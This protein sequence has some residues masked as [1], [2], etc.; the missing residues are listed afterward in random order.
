MYTV[1][2]HI[3]PN[4]K[5]YIGITKQEPEQRWKNG[6]GYKTNEHFYRAILKYGWENIRH[7]IV[8]NGLTK[9]QACDLEIELIAK[10][11][12]TNPKHGYNN[13]MGGETNIPSAETRKKLSE[14]NKGANNPQ[15]GKHPSAETLRK[16]SEATKGVNN[17][18]YGKHHSHEA[19]RKMSEARKGK[20][21]FWKG[22]HLSAETRKK[23]SE[24]NKGRHLSA[25]HR[26]KISESGKRH[27]LNN[28]ELQR[29][30]SESVKGV[31]NPMYGKHHS[32]ESRQKM[33]E[34]RKGTNLSDETRK[35]ISESCKG[36]NV[37]A[38]ICVETG[39]LYSSV[40]EAAE[41]IGV[42]RDAVGSVV[43]GIRKTSGGYHW[44]YAD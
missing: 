40:T 22:K 17:P 2:K 1:Y 39:T 10:Y 26:Q 37:K 30:R 5:V 19:R 43:R 41:S 12:S 18:H 24:A 34:A 14:A 36:K 20:S 7:E 21:S 25:E 11:D 16:L 23:L 9:E 15:Y 31:N 27:Y 29:K 3:A 35:K 13:T 8:A 28:P 33:S 6:N 32:A 44:K 38:V 4:G 42:T